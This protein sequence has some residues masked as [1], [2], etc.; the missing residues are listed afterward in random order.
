MDFRRLNHQGCG[1]RLTGLYSAEK[2]ALR[3]ELAGGPILKA[4]ATATQAYGSELPGSPTMASLSDPRWLAAFRGMQDSPMPFALT[5]EER[6]AGVLVP[7]GPTRE[8]RMRG[9]TVRGGLDPWERMNG[10]QVPGGPTL[11]E[12]I[13]GVR[14]R[15][16]RSPMEVLNALT[17][18]GALGRPAPV[19]EAFSFKP[20]QRVATAPP[21][22]LDPP[23]GLPVVDPFSGGG[24]APNAA[25][26]G[27]APAESAANREKLVESSRS[28]A[29]S[30][31][32][33]GVEGEI[34]PL[35]P[36][37]EIDPVANE[38]QIL[39]QLW[40]DQ[41][42]PDAA[43]E[44]NL[45]RARIL[46]ARDAAAPL[47]ASLLAQGLLSCRRALNSL[48][49]DLF[50]PRKEPVTDRFGEQR[51]ADFDGFISRL[52]LVVTEATESQSSCRIERR[53]L[54]LLGYRFDALIERLG[55]GVHRRADLAEGRRAYLDTWR[56][57][58]AMRLYAAPSKT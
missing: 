41:Y 7:G 1:T 9:V 44:M 12:R 58:Q 52:L 30:R 34:P 31:E 22:P 55:K 20:R 27:V 10:V 18:S 16:G 32:L 36:V 23:T 4:M 45:A 11:E 40:L 33:T 25:P 6:M 21:E 5:P 19:G 37:P 42:S 47:R 26:E 3:E 13:R 29:G 24:T 51:R 57:I 38:E 48:A 49:D 35:R 39:A 8:E 50:A 56:V 54:R 17:D 46:E 2:D 15:G 28:K 43:V 53:E 14:R